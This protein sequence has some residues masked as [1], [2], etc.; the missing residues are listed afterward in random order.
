TQGWQPRSRDEQGLLG[1]AH[2]C[3][4]PRQIRGLPDDGGRAAQE[5]RRT[6][7]DP[8]RRLRDQGRRRAQAERGGRIPELSGGARL[9]PLAGMPANGVPVTS[10]P[11]AAFVKADGL[12]DF[13]VPAATIAFAELAAQ[14]RIVHVIG[15]TGLADADEAKIKAAA[16]HA[17][18]VRSGNMSL[19]V[20]LLAVLVKQAAKA[21]DAD[22]DVEILEMHHRHK[23]DAPSGTALMLGEAAAAGRGVD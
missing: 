17:T 6:F 1:G 20:N 2:R 9:L 13:T 3:H 10:D 7:P 18:I 12:I 8:W 15:T 14:A 23:V 19:G 16:R 4:R 21:L 5:V 11:L 22:F